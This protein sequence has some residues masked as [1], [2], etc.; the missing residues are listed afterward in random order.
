MT[1]T[2][3]SWP[4]PP[5]RPTVDEVVVERDVEIPMSDGAR[6][7]ADVYRPAAAGAYPALYAVSPY[8]K[9][10]AHLP[11]IPVFRWRESGN[12][13]WWVRHG[14]VFVHADSRGAGKSLPGDWCVLDAREQEDLHDAIEWTAEQPWCTGRVGMT[15]ESY[16]A[17]V[18]WLAA[19]QQPPHLACIAPYDG[20][21]DPYRDLFF[22]GG[23][24]TMGFTTWWLWD[25]R[26]RMLL[27]RPGPHDRAVMRYDFID[28]LLRHP[29]DD[30]FWAERSAHAK[31]DRI[32]VPFYSMSNWTMVGIHLRA[33]LIA[34][35]ELP[36]PKKLLVGS[37]DIGGDSQRFYH[38]EA[39]HTE[40]LRFFDHWLKDD[41]NGIMD[42]PPVKVF[43]RNGEGFR[44]EHEWPLARTQYT[45]LY[46]GPGPTGTA[47]SRNDGALTWDPPGSDA[48]PT[49]YSYPDERWGGWPILGPAERSADGQIDR[50]ANI[51]TFTSDPLTDEIEVTGPIVAKLWLSSDQPDT[52]L[53][54]S[55]MDVAPE[56]APGPPRR[57][58]RG[59]L[60]ASHRGL[61][62]A[63]STPNRP[64]HDHR[65]P[66]PLEPG[67]VYELSVE[68]W[69][70]SW[71][72]LPGHRIR[73]EVSNA[74][75]PMFDNPI[76]HHFG[77]KTGTD[78][79][80]HDVQ[81]A[82][83]VVLPII[84]SAS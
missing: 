39:L 37:G 82:S 80:H 45:P 84:P 55:L 48:A 79:I 40:L 41:K 4:P 31:F 69:P 51:L 52:D 47:T 2:T 65:R 68:I 30:D 38:S 35:E 42:E 6:L 50:L 59:W 25:V 7:V 71:V 75:S 66:E 22:H 54:V 60:R 67:Q 57:V 16:Y 14:Y 73:I 20:W 24:P 26:A 36:G 62:P 29:S 77:V 33:N 78:S 3:T 49:T 12:I 43:V 64:F 15:G 34:F 81:H 5:V 8:Q 9:D 74:D 53:V 21:I 18:Q 13:E 28:D 17:V 63:R 19:A 61:D 27:D 56:S 58:T 10:L 76:N 23:M 11:P 70:T 1:E 72:F 46:L 44:D 32:R 83:H